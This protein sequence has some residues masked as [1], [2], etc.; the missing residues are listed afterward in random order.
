HPTSLKHMDCFV[1]F[2][3]CRDD[4]KGWLLVVQVLVPMDVAVGE[5]IEESIASLNRG[6]EEVYQDYLVTNV[7]EPTEEEIREF[8]DGL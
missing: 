2:F 4:R 7:S 5:V 1:K 6:Q 3:G 8:L